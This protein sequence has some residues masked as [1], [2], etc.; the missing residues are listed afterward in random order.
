MWQKQPYKNITAKITKFPADTAKV[1]CMPPIALHSFQEPHQPQM[2]RH[3]TLLAPMDEAS[4]LTHQVSL[5]AEEEV[6]EPGE[7]E[8]GTYPETPGPAK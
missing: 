1:R 5:Q 3:P 2:V 6:Q 7:E 8:K 4:E